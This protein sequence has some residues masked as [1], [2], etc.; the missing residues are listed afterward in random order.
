LLVPCCA[1]RVQHAPDPST[2]RRM[3]PEDT[4]KT[5]TIQV[6]F[7]GTDNDWA[8]RT[9]VRRRFELIAAAEDPQYPCLYIEGVGVNTLAGKI[10]GVGMKKRVLQAY[11]FLA[12]HWSKEHQDKIHILGFS[13]GAFQARMLA[14]I[15]AHCGLPDAT[16]RKRSDKDLGRLA[17]SVWEQCVKELT[18]PVES[19]NTQPLPLSVWTRHL[20]ANQAK[21]R[22]NPKHQSWSFNSPTVQFLGLWD[23]VPALPITKL[24]DD[25]K[26]EKDEP[27]RYKVRPYPNIKLVIH[28]LALDEKRSRFHPLLVG[29]PIDPKNKVYEVWFPGAHADVGGGYGDSNDMAGTTLNWMQQVL[30]R[31][32]VSTRPF[33]FYGDAHGIM[34][35]P[36][37]A[38]INSFGSKTVSRAIR[39]G[40]HIDYS[41]FKRANLEL[42]PE[43]DPKKK[44]VFHAKYQPTLSVTQPDGSLKV[45]ALEGPYTPATAKK[46]LQRVGLDLYDASTNLDNRAEGD[47]LTIKQM[48]DN[49]AAEAPPQASELST[50]TPP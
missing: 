27:Q 38:P 29:P 32:K 13:R 8:V 3:S 39:Y 5:K 44:S 45:L 47:P 48:A 25:G 33:S 23:T 46:A 17:E 49:S 42:H 7:D 36:E 1:H 4:G 30:I 50:N 41:V 6:F 14:G 28:A 9:N 19:D 37:Q 12:R 2:S 40:S 26:V 24:N 10:L 31:E 20:N 11:S 43:E 21:V 34:H 18:D 16:D 35:H 15:I 22:E